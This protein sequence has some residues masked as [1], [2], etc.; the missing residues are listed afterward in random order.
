[1]ITR[2]GYTRK[3][4]TRKAYTRSDG[5]KVKATKVPETYVPPTKITD[6]GAPGKGKKIIDMTDSKHL[7]KFG[8][9]LHKSAQ[10]RHMS[11]D[12]AVGTNGYSWTIKRLNAVKILHKNTNPGYSQKLDSDIKYLHSK[13]RS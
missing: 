1:M 11:E 10:E 9:S 8:F 12:R 13:Y 7:G 3:A 5:T 6:R 2:S 4:Y